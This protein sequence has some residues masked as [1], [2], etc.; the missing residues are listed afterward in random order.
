MRAVHRDDQDVLAQ[1][2]HGVRSF[3]SA[4]LMSGRGYRL[5]AVWCSV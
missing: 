2:D 1:L 5:L 4:S 3:G